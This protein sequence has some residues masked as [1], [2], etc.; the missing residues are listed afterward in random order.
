MLNF[1]LLLEKFI[2]VQWV[3]L[4]HLSNFNEKVDFEWRVISTLPRNI[5]I[6]VHIFS[7]S[8]IYYY[9]CTT[10][11]YETF[12]FIYFSMISF[13]V[14]FCFLPISTQSV[15]L[16]INPFFRCRPHLIFPS[17]ALLIP[18]NPIHFISIIKWFRYFVSLPTSIKTF[19]MH[20]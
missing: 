14:S 6:Y 5:F 2:R 4:F 19:C 11:Y 18:G 20:F 3:Q 9:C 17:S 10:Y 1:F 12:H 16:I 13:N 8:F 7:P 15:S